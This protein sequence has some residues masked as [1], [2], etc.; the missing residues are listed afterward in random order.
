MN[1]IAVQDI[2]EVA[3]HTR[4]PVGAF[5]FVQRGLDY[6]VRT[7]HGEL[8]DD[9]LLAP[10]QSNRHIDGRQLCYGLRDYAVEQYG[11]MAKAVLRSWNIHACEDFGRIVF[12]MVDS[13][14]MHKQDHDSIE[15]FHA[16]FRFSEAFAP[17]F[18]LQDA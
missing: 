2:V 13:G 11:L 10:Q 18:Q 15:D 14:L 1:G 16:V 17:A 5:L 9:E 4:Y 12:A 8:D 3:K 7:I 6:T